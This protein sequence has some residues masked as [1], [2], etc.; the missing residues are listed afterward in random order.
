MHLLRFGHHYVPR[1]MDWFDLGWARRDPR[2]SSQNFDCIGV[3]GIFTLCWLQIAHTGS[4]G[5]RAGD[6]RAPRL[7]QLLNRARAPRLPWLLTTQVIPVL[8]FSTQ[9]PLA[10]EFA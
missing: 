8:K 10:S 2:N 4:V 7:A 3:P 1:L 6:E 5:A 9:L